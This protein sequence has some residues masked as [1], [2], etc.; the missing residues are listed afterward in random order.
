MDLRDTLSQD[1]RELSLSPILGEQQ[2][3]NVA[4]VV[5]SPVLFSHQLASQFELGD[6]G[7]TELSEVAKA[8]PST[9]IT[10]LIADLFLV[11]SV[12]V[13]FLRQWLW[14]VCTVWPLKTH[15]NQQAL[16]LEV[17]KLTL[18]VEAISNSIESTPTL[19]KPHKVC[20][21]T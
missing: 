16:Q 10:G 17:A 7:R 5:G 21:P 3:P 20:M 9:S 14:F 19:T 4:E 18:K 2:L 13:N 12:L 8:S 6:I 15:K 11:F 1:S